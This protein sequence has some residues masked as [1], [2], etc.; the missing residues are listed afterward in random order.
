MGIAPER[1]TFAAT[2]ATSGHLRDAF[3]RYYGIVF[4]TTSSEWLGD[5]DMKAEFQR[6]GQYAWETVEGLDVDVKQN[7]TDLSIDTDESYTLTIAAPRAK[8]EANSVYGAMHG[9]ESFSQLVDRGSLVNGTV[10][11]DKPRY[12]FRA[13]MIDTARHFYH[14]QV[15]FQHLDAMSY[16]KMNVLHCKYT[17]QSTVACD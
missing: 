4:H 5:Q 8:I 9:L 3:T 2:G 17:K 1:F 10:I 6:H 16:A 7:H 15:I 14:K 13:V 12:A 11:T